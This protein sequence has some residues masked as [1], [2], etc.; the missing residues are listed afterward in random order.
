[1]PEGT[2]LTKNSEICCPEFHV[3][4]KTGC[5]VQGSAQYDL[6]NRGSL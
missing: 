2:V 1:M 5:G 4:H 3:F 6:H